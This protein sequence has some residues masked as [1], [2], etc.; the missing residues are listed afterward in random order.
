MRGCE[1][2]E[3]LEQLQHDSTDLVVMSVHY[4]YS[5]VVVGLL[6]LK[7]VACFSS[8]FTELTQ[9]STLNLNCSN[10]ILGYGLS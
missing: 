7:L 10:R 4:Q 5:F 1:V 9:L 3:G 6:K 2:V 8:V